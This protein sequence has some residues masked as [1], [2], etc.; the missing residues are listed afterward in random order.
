MIE[1][2]KYRH[3][4]TAKAQSDG[5]NNFTYINLEAMSRA[6]KELK[7]STFKLWCYLNKNKDGYE[8]SLSQIAVQNFT[9]ISRSSYLAGFKELY[10][11]G[12]LT[13]YYFEKLGV[14][15]YL[16]LEDGGKNTGL[17]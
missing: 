7:P 2:G 10:D 6:M 16:F 4:H 3:I 12:Y 1:Q 9:G 17:I 14:E 13:D 5:V 8:F 15:G 11:K